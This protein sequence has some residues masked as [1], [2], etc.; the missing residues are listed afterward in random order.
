MTDITID[1]HRV[2]STVNNA[3]VDDPSLPIRL[4]NQ[5]ASLSRAHCFSRASYHN[6]VM[7]RFS[8]TGVEL[9]Q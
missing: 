9:P 1:F 5:S 3:K 8:S 6:L 7:Q 4:M 2:S